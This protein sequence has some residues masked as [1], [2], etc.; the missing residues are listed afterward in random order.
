MESKDKNVASH[1]GTFSKVL[2]KYV[3]NEKILDLMT[4]LRKMTLLPVLR[5]Q[6]FVP[7]LSLKLF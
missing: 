2:G 4:A 1:N 6:K 3:R 5:L 7:S